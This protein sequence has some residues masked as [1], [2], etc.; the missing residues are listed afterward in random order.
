M[1]TLPLLAA[2]L[3]VAMLAGCSRSPEQKAEKL[4]TKLLKEHIQDWESYTPEGFGTL[5]SAFTR[6]SDHNR[7]LVALD[8]LMVYKDS[9]DELRKTAASFEGLNIPGNTY[10]IAMGEVNRLTDSVM[11]KLNT[12]QQL[13]KKHQP[14]FN[15]W[16]IEHRFKANTVLGT[17]KQSRYLFYLNKDLTAVSHYEDLDE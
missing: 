11:V 15:G 2:C 6:A 5:D 7:Y 12:L 16:R 3:A 14:A 17:P 10:A 4:I 9:C 1:K 13:E 8:E